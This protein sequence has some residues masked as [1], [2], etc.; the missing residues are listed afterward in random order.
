MPRVVV[1]A[2][3]ADVVGLARVT[4]LKG[5]GRLGAQAGLARDVIGQT[6]IHSTLTITR[7]HPSWYILLLLPVADAT[8]T[9][10]TTTT[11]TREEE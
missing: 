8:T 10:A 1:I 9:T 3:V 2:V 4:G 5:R 6:P 7:P 11:T